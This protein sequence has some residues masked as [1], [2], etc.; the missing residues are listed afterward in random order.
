MPNMI[1]LVTKYLPVLDAQY[2]M[3]SRSAILDVA[4]EFV[5]AT[6]DAKKIKIQ[7]SICL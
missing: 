4:P 3:E 1:E 6:R 7:I 5:Q 2:K